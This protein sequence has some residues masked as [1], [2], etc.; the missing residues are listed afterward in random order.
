MRSFHSFAFVAACTPGL[1]S[2]SS[3]GTDSSLDRWPPASALEGDMRIPKHDAATEPVDGRDGTT[4]EPSPEEAGSGDPR[5]LSTDA[6]VNVDA[7][8]PPDAASFADASVAPDAGPAPDGG[9]GLD[10]G[11]SRDAGLETEASIAHD[12]GSTADGGMDAGSSLDGGRVPDA[13]ALTDAGVAGRRCSVVANTT[14]PVG[15]YNPAYVC[16]V[17][18]EDAS[19]VLVRTLG[20]FAERRATY[21]TAYKAALG[22][23]SVDTISGA[24]INADEIPGFDAKMHTLTWDLRNA[25]GQDL[26]DGPYRLRLELT[27]H[28]GPGT[29]VSL[30]FTKSS[31]SIDVTLPDADNVKG[32][33]LTCPAAETP[34]GG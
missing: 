14:S 11:T 16:S 4:S 27:S 9:V 13:G 21:L 6:E 8:L 1:L 23:A 20:Y 3:T 33:R 29:T 30:G 12:G 2:C 17:W 5:T 22:A 18:I 26:E 32:L 31:A 34:D 7:S 25:A 28:N 19:G 15:R 24:T 10:A